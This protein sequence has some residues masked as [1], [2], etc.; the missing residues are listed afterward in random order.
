M[1][2]A[3]TSIL[4]MQFGDNS[5]GAQIIN[6]EDYTYSSTFLVP[7]DAFTMRVGSSQ[8]TSDMRQLLQAGQKVQLFMQVFDQGGNLKYQNPIFTGFVD[9]VTLENSRSGT[10]FT[11]RGRNILGPLC[12]SGIDPWSSTYKFVETQTLADVVGKC[13]NAFGITSFWNTDK[14]NRLIVSGRDKYKQTF[15]KKSYT[16]T[17]DS[18]LLSE[19]PQTTTT[20]VD[21]S[22]YLDPTNTFDLS[23][24]TIQKLQ[25]KHDQTFMEFIEENLARFGVTAWAMADGSGVVIGQPDY[26]QDADFNLINRLDGQGNNVISGR[27]EIDPF[28]MPSMIIAKGFQGGGDFKN[29]RIK[30]CRVNE[31]LGY[32]F[33]KSGPLVVGPGT[34]NGNTE[35]LP[36]VQTIINQFKGLEVL[37]P[38]KDLVTNYAPFFVPPSNPKVVYWEDEH[39]RTLNQLRAA[40]YRKMSE[41]QRKGFRLHYIVQDHTQDG[42][43]WKHNTIVNVYDEELGVLNVPFWVLDVTFKKSRNAGTTTEL[44][45]IPVGSLLLGPA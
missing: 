24:K 5:P 19:T 41:Y 40:C 22:L 31:F 29:T 9:Q 36:E 14:Q 43:V 37:Q 15:T 44:T 2:N 16:I 21:I 20:T 13:F 12:D 33:I 34:V 45:L 8:I 32:P 42:L 7:C 18:N 11:L 4:S 30:T 26:I 3:D 1:V 25:P 28:S 6:W 27:L 39:S 10:F 17:T 23:Q 35:V 38:N